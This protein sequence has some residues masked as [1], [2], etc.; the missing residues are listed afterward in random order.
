MMNESLAFPKVDNSVLC[1]FYCM[2]W[3]VNNARLFIWLF[4]VSHI[5]VPLCKL[6]QPNQSIG[7]PYSPDITNKRYI[8]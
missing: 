5:K 4:V 1:M 6:C 7:T 2:Q 8:L 3:F